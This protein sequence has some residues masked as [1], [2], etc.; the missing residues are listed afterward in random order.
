MREDYCELQ[1]LSEPSKVRNMVRCMLDFVD[2]HGPAS[3]VRED[4]K[5][6]FSELLYNAVIHGNKRDRSKI[7][8]ARLEAAGGHLRASIQDE[9][10]GFDYH[11]A[12]ERARTEAALQSEHGRGMV[13]VCA[14]TDNLS[15]NESGNQVRFEKRLR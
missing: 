3:E 6:V 9:G 8:L 12:L 7:V 10:S 15:Y 13:L 2:S 11:N 5:L 4:L 1:F 14:L